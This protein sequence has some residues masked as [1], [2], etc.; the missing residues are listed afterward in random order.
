MKLP[1]NV[2]QL[3]LVL[4]VAALVVVIIFGVIHNAQRAAMKTDK[5]VSN[6]QADKDADREEFVAKKDDTEEISDDE[7]GTE[8]PKELQPAVFSEEVTAKLAAMTLEEKVAQ[9][10]LITPEALTHTDTV[11][12]AGEGTKT[13]VSNYPVGGLVYA[14]ANFKNAQQTQALFSGVQQFSNERIGLPMFLAIQEVGG[15]DNSPL[16]AANGF[17]QQPSPAEIGASG[18]PEEAGKAADG[19]ASYMVRAGMNLN[20]MPVAELAGGTD[21]AHDTMCYGTD[22]STASAMVAEA[23]NA[24]R[25]KGLHTAV[26]IFPGKGIDGSTEEG[27]EAWKNSNVLVFQ[28]CVNAGTDCIIM[29]NVTCEKL[30]GEAELFCSMSK[31]AVYYLRNDLGYTGILMTDSLSEEAVTGKYSSG[32]AAVMAVKSGIN[33]I[34]RP[35]NFEEAYQAVLDAVNNSEIPIETIDQAVGYI[36]TQKLAMAGGA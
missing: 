3:L 9:M 4:E 8:T 11:E 22:A 15:S 23:V 16:A 28:S 10:F 31:D 24:S 2:F 30:T 5:P 13:A 6:I 18:K 36:L 25:V 21:A 20:L 12:V 34:Y 17:Q 26:G 19:I 1:R 33:M 7:E 35:A 14:S 29:G 32:E 27:W